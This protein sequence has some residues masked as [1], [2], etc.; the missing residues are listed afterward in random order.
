MQHTTQI[1]RKSSAPWLIFAALVFVIVIKYIWYLTNSGCLGICKPAFDGLPFASKWNT[2][3][4][5]N[6]TIEQQIDNSFFCFSSF[7]VVYFQTCQLWFKSNWGG[8]LNYQPK[9]WI[10]WTKW[11]E[12]INDFW[13]FSW[14]MIKPSRWPEWSALNS[15]RIPTM[16]EMEIFTMD[17]YSQQ[18][19]SV[20]YEIIKRKGL[21]NCS[22]IAMIL[23]YILSM[24]FR[25]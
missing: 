11:K 21:G 12:W 25:S 15:L 6:F 17:F 9:F 5:D 10:I 14:K 23:K 1:K 19:P 22:N 20:W 3:E 18:K 2:D 7:S 13:D 16:A 24:A 4:L 8:L